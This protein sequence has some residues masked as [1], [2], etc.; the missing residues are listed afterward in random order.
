M[1]NKIRGNI[2]DRPL[3]KKKER[4]WGYYSYSYP[5]LIPLPLDPV[6]I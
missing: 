1:A 6:L 4:Q 2:I 5:Q 3:F